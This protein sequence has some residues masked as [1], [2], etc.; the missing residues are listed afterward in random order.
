[1][2][3]AIL[4]LLAA[5]LAASQPLSPTAGNGKS[6]E[7]LAAPADA[8][9]EAEKDKRG[10]PE[11][12]L[13]IKLLNTG[14]SDAESA[15]EAA[16][17]KD[18]AA[19]DRWVG[20]WTVGLTIALVGATFLQFI[21][22]FVQTTYVRR[23]VQVAERA[24]TELE[25]PYVYVDVVD[26]TAEGS[27][28][29]SLADQGIVGRFRLDII[30]HG[31]TPADLTRIHY[32]TTPV[33]GGGIANAVDPATV[34]GRELPV[35]IVAVAGKPYSE[36]ETTSASVIQWSGSQIDRHSCW[37]VGFVRYRDIFGKNHITGFTRVFDPIGGRFVAR[38]GDTYNYSRA[39]KAEDIPEPSSR[40]DAP[41]LALSSPHEPPTHDIT[42]IPY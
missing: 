34:G 14:K 37:V 9:K 23:S 39:D 18:K 22:L 7:H 6:D 29:W 1:M 13:S 5:A 21:A 27:S 30:N 3:L 38:G 15:Q 28:G 8:P 32:E 12:P 36:N 16:D 20:D 4:T 24:L 33:A 2:K 26:I 31:R 41:H 25:R 17:V 35:G 42:Q 40:G 11:A 19:Q 10:T